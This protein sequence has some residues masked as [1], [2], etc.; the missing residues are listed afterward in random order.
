MITR[1]RKSSQSGGVEDKQCV[2]L[3]QLAQG[4]GVRDSK[5]PHAGHITLTAT[6]FA[7]LVNAIKHAPQQQS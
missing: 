2:E 5:N 7:G 4:I 6:E 3:G 1:W